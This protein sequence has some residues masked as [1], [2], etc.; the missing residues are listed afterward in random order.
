MQ[1]TFLLSVSVEGNDTIHKYTCHW[2][3]R[4]LAHDDYITMIISALGEFLSK[5]HYASSS[6][7]QWPSVNLDIISCNVGGNKSHPDNLLKCHP[8]CHMRNG[9]DWD[10]NPDPGLPR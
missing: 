2:N 8:F 1:S 10:S 6:L 3:C 7:H 4:P 9:S 5:F